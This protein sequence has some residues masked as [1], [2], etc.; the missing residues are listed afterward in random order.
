MENSSGKTGMDKVVEELITEQMR[1]H[2]E[3]Y[4]KN[5]GEQ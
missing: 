4:D 3:I 2:P 5:N 1:L